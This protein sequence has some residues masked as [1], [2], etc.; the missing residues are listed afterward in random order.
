MKIKDLDYFTQLINL[1]KFY[2][3]RQSFFGESTNDYLCR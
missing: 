1:K 2:S 3:G